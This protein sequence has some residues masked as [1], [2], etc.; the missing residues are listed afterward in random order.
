MA[1]VKVSVPC[2]KM[3]VGKKAHLAR[4]LIATLGTGDAYSP[5]LGEILQI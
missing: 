4:G 3:C 5:N 1:K 2:A